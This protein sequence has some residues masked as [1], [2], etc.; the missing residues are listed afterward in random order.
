MTPHDPTRASASALA[1][2]VGDTADFADAWG[3]RP[4]L[5][6]GPGYEDLLNLAAVDELL[7]TRGLR[8]PFLRVAKNG[9]TLP[10]R[11][12]TAA[13]GVGAAIGDQ[14]SDPQLARHFADG[15]TIVLQGLHRTWAPI[16]DFAADL[17]TELG[18]PVQANA[19]VTP[20]QSQGFSAH[21]D[22]HDVFVL[23][24]AGE[25]RWIIHEP[26]LQWPLRSEPW[27]GGGRRDEVARAAEADPVLDVVLTPGDCL[28]LPRGY[29]HAATALGGVSAH[30]TLGV[31]VWTRRHLA[32]EI[33]ERALAS[34]DDLRRPLALGVDVGRVTDIADDAAAVRAA[35]VA[36]IEAVPDDDLARL[37]DA[38]A[39]DTGRAAPISPLAQA[40]AT[41]DLNEHTPVVV[42][43][44]L[45]LRRITEESGTRLRGR[46][47]DVVVDAPEALL[48]TL[49]DGTTHTCA[50]LAAD[51]SDAAGVKDLVVALL[52]AGVLVPA[53]E[54]LG[55]NGVG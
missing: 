10:E 34:A 16:I 37:L 42:R 20:P 41:R 22:V 51:H 23:Q 30:L 27:E 18:H 47:V 44:H 52:R 32:T 33:V 40:A 8:T 15:A 39:Y 4:S 31:H 53:G 35:L 12:F 14:V 29:L 17:A 49:L 19:Y 43:A 2:V 21:Y 6:N 24:L 50:D 9:S 26:V 13:G 5:F 3:R 45:R 1:R 11:S 7:S 46:G 28:Y 25:K 36:A 48:D 55:G 38:R 54:G